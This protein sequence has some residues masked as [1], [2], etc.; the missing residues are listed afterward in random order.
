MGKLSVSTKVLALDLATHFGWACGAAS[1]ERPLSGHMKLPSDPTGL[2]QMASAYHDWLCQIR[3]QH[4]VDLIVFEAP[5][6]GM[7][8]TNMRAQ[9][10]LKGLIWHTEF[11]A[12]RMKTQVVQVNNGTWKKHLCGSG[13]VSKKIKPYPVIAALDRMG[14]AIKDDNEAD[15]IGIWLH[16]V[17]EVDR[18]RSHTM[19]PLFAGVA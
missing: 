2:G 7:G 16:T 11:V 8:M 6:N 15:A 4:E 12:F 3:K 14:Y 1:D 13:K 19:T 17:H 9:M 18:S 10:I 5:I